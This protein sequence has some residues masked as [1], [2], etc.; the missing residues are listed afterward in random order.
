M[1]TRRTLVLALAVAL[2]A[3]FAA[4]ERGPDERGGPASTPPPSPSPPFRILV[5]SKTARFRHA[6]IPAGIAAIRKIGVDRGASGWVVDA[7]EDASAFRDANLARYR[8][9]VFL[10]TTGDVLDAAQQ[11]AFERYIRGGGGFAGIHAASDTEY[12]WAWYGRLLG[13][14]FKRH[15]KTQRATVRVLDR[16]HPSTADLPGTWIR[17][18]EWYDFRTNPRG[19]V[20]VLATVD[21]AT[22]TGGTMGRDHPIAW[23]Q[24]FEGGRSWYTA[25]GHTQETYADDLFLTHLEGGILTAAGAA[26]ADCRPN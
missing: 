10:L 14:F 19:R 6:S 15:P 23:C 21:E 18:D 9:V 3:S 24:D 13:A 7:T 12:D 5:F 2:A 26:S 20:H 8:A 25:M 22:Y 17:T 11:A 16:A 1:M 4:C